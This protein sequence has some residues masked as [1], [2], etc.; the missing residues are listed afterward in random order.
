[1]NKEDILKYMAEMDSS[2]L[3]KLYKYAELLLIP[4]EDL[5]VNV[6]MRQ[7]LDKAFS[8][9]DKHFPEWTDRSETDF[10][11]FLIELFAQF[12]EKDFWYINAFGN[13]SLL[14][15]KTVY[16]EAFTEAISLGYSPITF[17][18]S[19]ATF[20]VTFA[21]GSA[22]NYQ[23][24][25]LVVKH[26]TKDLYFTN[27]EPF[28]VAASA[29]NTYMPIV[30]SEGKL[31]MESVIFNGHTIY[32]S[33]QNVDIE[34]ISLEV[35]GVA[36]TR[37]RTFGRSSSDSK[38]FIVL[39]EQDGSFKIYFGEDGYGLKPEHTTPMILRYRVCSGADGN[40]DISPVNIIES[41]NS[42]RAVAV[43]M[44]EKPT[45]GSTGESLESIKNRTPLYFSSKKAAI[46]N[47]ITES[48][49][50][51]IEGV[52][53]S[54]SITIGNNVYL[55][56]IHE[57]GLPATPEF[58]NHVQ[59]IIEPLL[60]L[61]YNCVASPTEYV[62][63]GP[64]DA[65]IYVLKGYNTLATISRVK[66]FIQDYTNPLVLAEYGQSFD[67]SDLTA[68]IKSRV[69]GVQ[70]VVYNIVAGNPAQNIFVDNT[71]IMQ[72][73]EISDINLNAYVI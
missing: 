4:E 22:Y 19:S 57:N 73:V 58:L 1:M 49:M 67:L 50:N 9:A 26:P 52:K 2:R 51:T 53:K 10:G 54:K 11:R 3:E 14:S 24:G 62:N 71:Q 21:P 70:N 68:K 42:R 47:T 25:E 66:Q 12:S 35:N 16:S 69:T 46:N 63:V 17:R 15:K 18:G 23:R 40:I 5:L 36:W 27:D 56:V 30:L 8:L 31:V 6:T 48:I 37:V 65:D 60:M 38:H 43:T 13:Q 59:S 64:I 32:C 39:P 33:K 55:R 20:G 61:G 44:L 34:S 29:T 72:K 45:G 7:M 28:T 41:A